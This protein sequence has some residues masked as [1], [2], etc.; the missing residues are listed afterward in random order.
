M[1]FGY[2]IFDIRIKQIKEA[3]HN[4]KLD[5]ITSKFPENKEICEEVLKKLNNT[6]VKIKVEE[7]ED[8][9][10][11]NKEKRT[12]S[13]YIVISDSIFIGNIKDTYT[14]IQT[15]CHECLH[16]IQPRKLLLF[17]FIFSNIYLLYFVLST[18]LTIA[19]VIK[20]TKTQIIILTLLSFIYYAVRSYLETDAMTKARFLAKDYMLRIHRK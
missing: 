16:S 3:R 12:D 9:S 11:D 5:E 19:G 1:L 15:V 4:K 10:K 2:F 6:K 14:R 7:T 17:N 8:S 18:I 20:D 13:L